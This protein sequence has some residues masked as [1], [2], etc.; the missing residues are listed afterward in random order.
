MRLFAKTI[1]AENLENLPAEKL[2]ASAKA[3]FLPRLIGAALFAFGFALL[4][5]MIFPSPPPLLYEA[6]HEAWG[7]AA[8]PF[9]ILKDLIAFSENLFRLFGYA[10]FLFPA[11]ALFWGGFLLRGRAPRLAGFRLLC[12]IPALLSLSACLA[13]FAVS[14]ESQNLLGGEAG[15]QLSKRVIA[16]SPLP[17]SERAERFVML[18]LGAFFLFL[19]LPG[20]LALTRLF[21]RG[22]GGGRCGGGRGGGRAGF[23]ETP[24]PPPLLPRLARPSRPSPLSRRDLPT[25]LTRL[26]AYAP[27]QRGTGGAGGGAGAAARIRLALRAV[28]SRDKNDGEDCLP[29]VNLLRAPD[30]LEAPA[31]KKTTARKDALRLKAILRDFGVEGEMRGFRPGPVVTLYEF[32]PAR[33][34]KASR[35]LALSD[36][37]ARSMGSRSARV[38]VM[39]EETALGIEIPNVSRDTVY[40]RP[41]LEEPLFQEARLRLPLALGRRIGGEAFIADLARMP[42]LLIAGTTGSGKSVS[43]NAMILSLLSRLSPQSCRMIMVDP[44]MLELSAYQGIPH[45]LTP[46][47]TDP[48]KA[49]AALQWTVREMERRYRLMAA[50]GARGIDAYRAR[51]R[52]EPLPYIVLIIDEMADLMLVAGK[53]IETALQRL[54]QMARAAGIHLITATQRPSVDVITGTIKAN[55]PTRISFQLASRIDSRTILGGDGAEQLLGQGDMLFMEGGGRVSRLHAPFVGDDEV[56][57][58]AENL[59]SSAAA[60]AYLDEI[61][62]EESEETLADPMGGGG[63]DSLYREAVGIVRQSGRASTS[64]LQRRLQIGYNRAARLLDRMEEEG[65]VSPPNHMGARKPIGEPLGGGGGGGGGEG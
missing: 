47:V 11:A 27:S 14:P 31:R 59:K 19:G 6:W 8:R 9:G 28:S 53:Q 54:A 26:R 62:A 39:A 58:V 38:S 21:R 30:P 52:A 20:S 63:G 42:H 45:L 40:L 2:E 60:P 57:A 61:T 29:I 36:D 13:L 50:T 46:V 51:R 15:L 56:E 4:M 65:I 18:A 43:I 7:G 37:I 64:F 35:I 16:S 41:L 24:P 5:V 23:V 49:L 25:L 3:R 44:K 10:A 12:L 55:F 1:P 33:G 34:V 22:G 48:K 32:V 17:P